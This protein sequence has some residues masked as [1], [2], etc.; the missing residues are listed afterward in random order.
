M[1]SPRGIGPRSWVHRKSLAALAPRNVWAIA[2]A[3]PWL[4]GRCYFQSWNHSSSILSTVS[5]ILPGF[6]SSHSV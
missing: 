5:G 4:G 3:C 1:R 6:G 2:C